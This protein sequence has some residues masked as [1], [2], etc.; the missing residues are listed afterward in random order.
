[1]NRIYLFVFLFVCCFVSSVI[2]MNVVIPRNKESRTKRVIKGIKKKYN[3]FTERY[4]K[5]F[6]LKDEDV[7][8]AYSMQAYYFF[9]KNIEHMFKWRLF[10]NFCKK[11]PS[12]CNYFKLRK[13]FKRIYEGSTFTLKK[14]VSEVNIIFN[15]FIKEYSTVRFNVDLK[16]NHIANLSYTPN[17]TTQIMKSLTSL[18]NDQLMENELKNPTWKLS[19]NY[20]T[21]TKVLIITV[22]SA[23]PGLNFFIYYYITTFKYYYSKLFGTLGNIYFRFQGSIKKHNVGYFSIERRYERK[24]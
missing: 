22:P 7:I 16:Q 15:Q 19:F 3:G 6:H 1:M 2:G 23:V 14:Y 13:E 12:P 9:D 11:S 8:G 17:L 24:T 18:I 4:R 20:L 5:S 10:Y 21:G